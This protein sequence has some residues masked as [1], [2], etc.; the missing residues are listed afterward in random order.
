MPGQ[1]QEDSRQQE[2]ATDEEA[3]DILTLSTGVVLDLLQPSPILVDNLM[4]SFSADEPHIPKVWIK[5]KERDEENPNDP[6]YL[7]A[8]EAWY[9]ES[10][11][12]S[13][14]ALLPTGSRIR[15]KP[16]DMPGPEEPDFADLMD[17]MGQPLG[18][19]RFSRY[20]QWVLLYATNP[21][22][23]AILGVKLLRRA[24]V[25]E[26][27]VREAQALFQ[28][29]QERIADSRTPPGGGGPDGGTVPGAAPRVGVG[30]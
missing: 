2:P 12:R 22:D 7:A 18:K 8:M 1:E 11:M 29:L 26:E 30:G 17:T 9:A 24:G 20:T 14:K 4:R 25:R 5:D 15:S 19:S 23:L 16:E 27:D 28:G 10:G 13:I 21:Q 3:E 6:D